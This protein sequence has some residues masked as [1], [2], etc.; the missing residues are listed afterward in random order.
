[1]STYY[2]EIKSQKSRV[3]GLD[4]YVVV[5]EVPEGGRR[6]LILNRDYDLEYSSG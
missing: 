6:L 2:L 4:R 1:M 3:G 5:Q